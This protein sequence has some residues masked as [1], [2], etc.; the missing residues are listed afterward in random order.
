MK[1]KKK[2]GIG[3]TRLPGRKNAVKPRASP[4]QR[5]AAPASPIRAIGGRGSGE[6]GREESAPRA[7]ETSPEDEGRSLP[8]GG[9]SEDPGQPQ[10][11]AGAG[12]AGC[13][14][15]GRNPGSG[16]PPAQRLGRCPP[17]V[18]RV[19]PP[20][21]P[22][23]SSPRRSPPSS[24]TQSRAEERDPPPA[25]LA[26]RLRGAGSRPPASS[27]PPA[28]LQLAGVHGRPSSEGGGTSPGGGR[29]ARWARG[30][31]GGRG[32]RR[33]AARR[34]G[35]CGSARGGRAGGSAR[36]RRAAAAHSARSRRSQQC[37][38]ARA[39]SPPR[40]LLSLSF[41]HSPRSSLSPALP[42]MS[43]QGEGLA[44]TP[45]WLRRAARARP[46]PPP[47]RSHLPARG[48][49]GSRAGAVGSGSGPLAR[50]MLFWSPFGPG[51]GWRAGRPP[52]SLTKGGSDP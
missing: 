1:K 13:D 30:P 31:G 14:R 20:S 51:E 50:E 25:R 34:L 29:A 10:P 43:D 16:P 21:P 4:H 40:S 2:K 24:S 5:P 45:S 35:R 6:S 11:S 41:S 48:R 44:L 23:L 26:A 46:R 39:P 47:D 8:A 9:R 52:L 32:A 12:W 33:P 42:V 7:P 49:G 17:Q 27:H 15:R 28:R 37:G 22:P 3:A 38:A 18:A 19:M 36:P